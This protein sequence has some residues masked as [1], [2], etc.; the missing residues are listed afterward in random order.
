MAGLSGA[1][2]NIDGNI[3][4]NTNDPK[5]LVIVGTNNNFGTLEIGTTNPFVGSVYF[6][7]TPLTVNGSPVI[8]GSLVASQITFTGS[9]TIHY[10][11]DLQST[12]DA[13]AGSPAFI[14]PNFTALVTAALPVPQAQ[15]IALASVSESV[16]AE[17]QPF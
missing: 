12:S 10:D 13:L 9:P 1:A 8:Y 14:A 4:N 17:A 15:P 11:L 7:K 5:R 16:P 3:S 6:P 2:M